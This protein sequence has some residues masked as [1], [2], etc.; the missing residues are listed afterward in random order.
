MLKDTIDTS[1][2]LTLGGERIDIHTVGWDS[3]GCA[4]A[5]WSGSHGSQGETRIGEPLIYSKRDLASYSSDEIEAAVRA[6][7][8][9]AEGLH[10]EEAAE[11][12]T[13]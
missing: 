4:A 6:E 9:S 2:A 10:A 13:R 7:W 12:G 5:S 1:I 8:E 3:F 11:R